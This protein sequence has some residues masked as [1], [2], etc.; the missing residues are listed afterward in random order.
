MSEQVCEDHIA[1]GHPGVN[2]GPGKQYR[3]DS[4]PPHTILPSSSF[5]MRGKKR[6]VLP[7]VCI[8]PSALYSVLHRSRLVTISDYPWNPSRSPVWSLYLA[9]LPPLSPAPKTISSPSGVSYLPPLFPRT[10]SY[11]HAPPL[12]TPTT[13]SARKSHCKLPAVCARVS[14]SHV[15]V[16]VC[17]RVCLSQACQGNGPC[18]HRLCAVDTVP[19]CNCETRL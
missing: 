15:G 13:P 19:H 10:P 3:M 17:A 18:V 12:L 1:S 11:L 9:F 4:D 5:I 6:K 16:H 7:L 14:R 2:T 8:F